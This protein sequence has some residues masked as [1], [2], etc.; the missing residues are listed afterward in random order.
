MELYLVFMS[1]WTCLVFWLAFYHK[2]NGNY[3]LSLLYMFIVGF[4]LSQIMNTLWP[5]NIP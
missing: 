2:K 5:P 4:N 3:N 1:F